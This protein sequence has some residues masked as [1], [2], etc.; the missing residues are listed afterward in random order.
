MKITKPECT[1]HKFIM[2]INQS[3]RVKIQ[4]CKKCG[5]CR[6]ADRFTSR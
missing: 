2:Y 3:T 4:M 5:M 1:K 6:S